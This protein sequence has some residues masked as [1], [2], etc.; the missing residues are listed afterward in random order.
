MITVIK[1]G[2]K[3]PKAVTWRPGQKWLISPKGW[4]CAGTVPCRLQQSLS[5]FYKGENRGTERILPTVSQPKSS[6]D[7]DPCPCGSRFTA[8]AGSTIASREEHMTGTQETLQ[9]ICCSGIMRV[10]QL[11]GSEYLGSRGLLR[12]SQ[13]CVPRGMHIYTEFYTST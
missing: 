6:Q 4:P 12:I 3:E 13:S 2:R 8:L 11:R 9:D 5:S 10:T 1:S 7:L